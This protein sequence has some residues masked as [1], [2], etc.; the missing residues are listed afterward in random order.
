MFRTTLIASWLSVFL[1]APCVDAAYIVHKFSGRFEDAGFG[2][3]V[4][5]VGSAFTGLFAFEESGDRVDEPFNGGVRSY[6]NPVFVELT[7]GDE[8]I[9]VDNAEVEVK[10]AVTLF[11]DNF[12]VHAGTELGSP[13]NDTLNGKEIRLFSINLGGWQ[14]TFATSDYPLS[15]DLETFQGGN[16]GLLSGPLGSQTLSSSSTIGGIQDLMEFTFSEGR[17][18]NT[19]TCEIPEPTASALGASGLLGLVVARWRRRSKKRRMEC[20]GCAV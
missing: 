2:G 16:I 15:I 12:I 8:T 17:I 14:D 19:P 18:C 3:P 10:N 7:V 20:V 6:Y 13:F 4:V 9:F 11:T 5:P 1:T